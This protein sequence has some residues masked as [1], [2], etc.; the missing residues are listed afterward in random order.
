MWFRVTPNAKMRD[1]KLQPE[2]HNSTVLIRSVVGTNLLPFATTSV[3]FW[4][5]FAFLYLYLHN[6]P[7]T[8]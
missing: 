5:L 3:Q 2:I 6:L 7:Q 8:Q 1:T 4:P